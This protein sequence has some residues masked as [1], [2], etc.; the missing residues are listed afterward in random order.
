[1]GEQ[2]NIVFLLLLFYRKSLLKDAKQA[3]DVRMMSD[4]RRCDAMTS[5]RRRCGVNDVASTL[6]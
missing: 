1:M 4:R 3:H 5:D 6:I 2:H